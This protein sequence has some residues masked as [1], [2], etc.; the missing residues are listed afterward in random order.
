[1]DALQHDEA[2]EIMKTL[3]EEV[4]AG[5]LEYLKAPI[6]ARRDQLV[7]ERGGN[8][9]IRRQLKQNNDEAGKPLK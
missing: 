7:Q 3:G 5:K 2:L 4:C 1:M 9:C 8:I 6:Y